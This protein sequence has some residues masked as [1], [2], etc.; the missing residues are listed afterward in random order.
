M[1]RKEKSRWVK[2]VGTKESEAFRYNTEPIQSRR[3]A[4]QDPASI[5]TSV[6]PL[7]RERAGRFGGNHHPLRL[8]CIEMVI[9]IS[10]LASHSRTAE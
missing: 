10:P 5:L 3:E 2:R 6:M 7:H 8:T 1:R 9:E 4:Q